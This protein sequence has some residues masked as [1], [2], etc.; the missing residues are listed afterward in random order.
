MEKYQHGYKGT[1]KKRAKGFK[2]K[3]KIEPRE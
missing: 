1:S 2:G 3:E